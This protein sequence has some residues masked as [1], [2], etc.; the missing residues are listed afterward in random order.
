MIQ[1]LRCSA[2][3]NIKVCFPPLTDF[4]RYSFLF[5]LGGYHQW[6]NFLSKLVCFRI[7]SPTR[8]YTCFPLF[9]GFF[10]LFVNNE[11]LWL[12]IVISWLFLSSFNRYMIK[13]RWHW[14]FLI[15]RSRFVLPFFVG[16]SF[17]WVPQCNSVILLKVKFGFLVFT[18][19]FNFCV[20]VN[21]RS[22]CLLNW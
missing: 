8:Y 9:K 18:G 11:S 14:V 2:S 21:F 22:I 12:F 4:E 20:V 5:Y 6:Q 19:F 1:S 17:K 3:K 13:W 10:I 16:K 7:C 15:S